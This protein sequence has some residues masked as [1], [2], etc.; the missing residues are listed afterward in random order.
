MGLHEDFDDRQIHIESE[1]EQYT[2]Y[3]YQTDN[4]GSWAGAL[5][6]KQYVSS[7]YNFEHVHTDGRMQRIVRSELGE[8]RMRCR[9]CLVCLEDQTEN[10]SQLYTSNH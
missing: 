7:P 9:L 8:R 5:P 4:N 3:E 1:K 2:P 6:V 10:C